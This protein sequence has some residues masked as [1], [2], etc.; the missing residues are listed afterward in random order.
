[1]TNGISRILVIGY[2]NPGR[3]DDGLGPAFAAAVE[4]L[5][6][7]GVSVDSDYQLNVEDAADLAAYD[8]VVFADAAVNGPEPFSFRAIHPSEDVS[9]TTHSI[10]PESVFGLARSLFGAST[11]A[12]ALGIRGYA[13]NEFGEGLSEGAQRNLKAAMRFLEPVL[14]QRSFELAVQKECDTMH[15]N[16]GLL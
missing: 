5:R 6:I 9:F 14:R 10:E 7:P 8:V 11:K 2:G 16:E 4:A 12:Y 15:I 1:M 13:F 3:L